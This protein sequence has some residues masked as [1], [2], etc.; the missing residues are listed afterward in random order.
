[1]S[2]IAFVTDQ[3]AIGKILDHLGLSTPEADKPPPPVPEVLRAAEHGDG[4]SAPTRLR[5]NR[6]GFR[7]PDYDP[8]KPPGVTRIFCFGGSSTFDPFVSDEETWVFRLGAALGSRLGHP[9]ET[10]NAGRYGYTTAEIAGLFLQRA[11]RH[12][13]DAIVVYSTYNDARVH[14]SPYFGRDDGPQLYGQPL[15]ALLSKNSALFTFLDYHLRYV[16]PMSRAYSR[17]VPADL[18][19]HAPPPEHVRFVA[20]VKR[21]REYLCHWYRWNVRGIVRVARD[22]GIK[23]L[24]ATQLVDPAYES[25][26]DRVLTETLR[27]IARTDQVPLTTS[28][29]R[30][31]ATRVELVSWPAMCIS[32]KR[33]PPSLPSGSRQAWA[34]SWSSRRDARGD[35]L[36]AGHGQ[37]SLPPVDPV[38]RRHL[39][40]DTA[41]A[42]A[43][44]LLKTLTPREGR[45]IK[46]RFGIGDGSEHTL[47]KVGQSF[48][49]TRE[50]I[51]QIEAKALRKLRHSSRSRKLKAF[52]EGSRI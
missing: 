51:R 35:S 19:A 38:L 20:D 6:W 25:V 31:W 47:E 10:I 18:H 48:H 23:V 40:G 52:L 46:M 11:L 42:L 4:W 3:M 43:N 7:G 29:R 15:L 9:V 27:E 8:V 22:N 36:D 26:E 50:R 34:R 49:V 41:A 16:W 2:L 5:I 12:Q 33:G 13:P 14:V 39:R 24:L 44:A 37:H 28:H 30:A 32:R 1:M 21:R 17:L 45:V